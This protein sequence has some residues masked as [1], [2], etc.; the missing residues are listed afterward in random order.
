MAIPCAAFGTLNSRRLTMTSPLLDVQ[1][2][3]KVYDVRSASGRVRGKVHAVND[4]SFQLWRGETYGLVGESGC[5]KSTTG[6]T[7]LRL[8]EPT[9]GR[10][11]FGSSD[12]FT[13]KTKQLRDL[14]KNIQMIFQDPYSSLNPRKR[15]GAI[16]EEA[17]KI[18][19]LYDKA[20]RREHAIQM[21]ERVGFSQEHYNRF[22]HEFSGGQRQ[23]I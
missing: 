17:M 21:L 19:G 10:A 11:L 22:P 16:L 1:G 20:G 2:L 4:V 18:H 9:E 23:R 14:R 12:V 6:R 13:M 5:G 15:V 3:S 7:L 8:V